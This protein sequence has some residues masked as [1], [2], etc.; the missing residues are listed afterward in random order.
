[1]QS[2]FSASNTLTAIGHRLA[3]AAAALVGLVS[4][5]GDAPLRIA[6]LR[7]ALT[8][9]AVLL[10]ARLARGVLVHSLAVDRERAGGPSSTS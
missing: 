1:V 9:G 7:G 2:T 5:L 4:L 8:W 10:V 6:C 3:V